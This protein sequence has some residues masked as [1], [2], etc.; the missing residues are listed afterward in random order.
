MTISLLREL[1]QG[2]FDTA[3]LLTYTLGLRFFEEMVLPRL[4]HLG[5]VRT[6]ILADEH[7]YRQSLEDSV[8]P[9]ACGRFYVLASADLPGAGIQHAKLLWLQGRERQV[10]YV[11]SHN[12]TAAGFNDQFECTVRLDSRVPGHVAPLREV[13]AAVSRVITPALMHV[14]AHTSAPAEREEVPT[15]HFLSSLDTPLLPQTLQHAGKADRLRV[16]TPFVDALA[17]KSLVDGCSANSVVLDVPT[18]GADISLEAA[19]SGLKSV[20]ARVSVGR[21]KDQR[22]LHAK[23][24]EFAGPL[25]RLL[26]IGSAN[27]T[28]AA[29]LRSVPQGGNL[30]F[31]VLLEG[32]VLPDSEGPFFEEVADMA[33]VPGTGRSW[34]AGR[35]PL[36]PLIIDSATW[37]DGVLDVSWRRRGGAHSADVFLIVGDRRIPCGASPFSLELEAAP[38]VIGLACGQDG[39]ATARSWVAFPDVLEAQIHRRRQQRWVEHLE[40]DDPRSYSAGVE[41]LFDQLAREVRGLLDEE[42]RHPGEEGGGVFRTPSPRAVRDAVET[43]AFSPDPEEVR[44]TAVQMLGGEGGENPFVILLALLARHTAPVPAHLQDD[45]SAVDRYERRRVE[46]DRRTADQLVRCLE[47]LGDPAVDWIATPANRT[48]F[49]LAFSF[50]AIATLWHHARVGRELKEQRQRLA[51]SIA[52]VLRALCAT[53]IGQSLLHQSEMTGPVL[54]GLGAAWEAAED[55][56]M[57][58]EEFR[59]VAR[60]IAGTDPRPLLDAWRSQHPRD[61]ELLGISPSRVDQLPGWQASVERL[62]GLAS[63]TAQL[64]IQQHW[65]LLLELET[66][67]RECAPKCETLRARAAES[68]RGTDVWRSYLS[69]SRLR[70]FPIVLRVSSPVCSSCRISIPT[71]RAAELMRGD[72]VVCERGHILLLRS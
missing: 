53:R 2:E 45:P 67:D 52:A 65:G 18:G 14:W 22:H 61:S 39:A 54:F 19:T 66:A 36:S 37:R 33:A 26:A 32:Q 60:R 24:Y 23:V 44:R 20:T 70:R 11:G 49:C 55:D 31:L 47:R 68:Y 6:A 51:E 21:L 13:H 30:E 1:E 63:S 69:A 42:E 62:C 10:A 56:S 41:A 50:K 3:V 72:A 71:K 57:L 28:Q 16:V 48:A 43:F 35:G 4:H 12:L 38:A 59:A 40:S 15:A 17:L 25:G 29:L 8:P 9:E 58:R 5:V 7:G 46:A 27:C 34:D 64:E